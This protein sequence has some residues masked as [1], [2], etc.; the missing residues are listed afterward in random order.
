MRFY[1]GTHEFYAG[2]DLH[3]KVMYVCVLDQGGQTVVHRNIPARPEPLLELLAPYRRDVVVAAECTFSWYW[4]ADCCANEQ[5]PFVLSHALYMKAIHGGKAR[6]DKIDSKK[7]AGLL[8][9]GLLPQA[10][11]YPARMREMRD[12]LRRRTY[13]V[14][15]R[16]EALSHVQNTN[17]QY[18]LPP[19][20]G[21]LAHKVFMR[22]SGKAMAFV[23]KRERKHGKGK[24]M[25]ILAARLGRAIYT[26]LKRREAFD[27]DRF[28]AG[29]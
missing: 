23:Q 13:V 7:I 4:L 1:Q 24:A 14:R 9:G 25:S 5:I 18:N 2:I 26:M 20:P 12:L 16:A 10:Y 11:V 6:N 17:S 27:E 8:R 3:T 21:R 22:E 29:V 19:L 28:F 15:K